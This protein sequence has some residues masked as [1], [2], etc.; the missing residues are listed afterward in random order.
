MPPWQSVMTLDESR[1]IVAGSADRL[2]DAVRNGADLRVYTE[3]RHEEHIEPGSDRK[4][5][6]QEVTDFRETLLIDNR[7]VAGIITLRQ[8]IALPDGFGPR[9][10]MSFF[11]YNENGEQAIARPHLDGLKADGDPGPS[12]AC[13]P[14][15]MPR[16]HTRNAWDADTNA[17]S[18]NFVYDFNVYRFMVHEVWE[19]VYAHDATGKLISGSLDAL[20]AAFQNGAEVKVAIAGLCDD[21][22]SD[23]ADGVLPHE[24]LIQVGSCYYY[25]Q[26]K[27][28]M[29]CSHPLVRVKPSIPLQY[30][31]RCWDFGWVMPRSDGHVARMLYDPYSL[32]S[33]RSDSRHAMRWFVSS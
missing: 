2:R 8:P 32:Q 28:F 25:S 3:F 20:A 7:W 11:L 18:E 14:A 9:A 4:E 33:M 19:E 6:I 26:S 5:L 16:Y 12:P 23:Q 24:L 15:N 10:S 21:V 22:A 27:Q 31:S 13:P 29:A 17:P 30:E 1:N